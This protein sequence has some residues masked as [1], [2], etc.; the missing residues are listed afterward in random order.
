MYL[1]VYNNINVFTVR[2]DE[3]NASLLNFLKDFK[4]ELFVRLLTR[5]GDKHQACVNA[6]DWAK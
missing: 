1:F 4:P 5:H 6:F 2:F 3:N